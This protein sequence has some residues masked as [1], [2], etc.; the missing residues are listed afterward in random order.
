LTRNALARIVCHVMPLTDAQIKQL[1]KTKAAG[2]RVN[3]AMELA[4]VTKVKVAEATGLRY[5]YV[6][7][8]SY[9]RYQTVTVENAHKFANFFGCAIEDL[10]PER[11]AV[12]S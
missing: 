6:T 9:N 5:T 1:R 8:V 4:E 10:F 12:A 7:D 11:E 3:R 2:N